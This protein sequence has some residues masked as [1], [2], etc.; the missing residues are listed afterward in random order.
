MKFLGGSKEKIPRLVYVDAVKGEKKGEI[1]FHKDVQIRQISFSRF[2]IIDPLLGR[3]GRWVKKN[4]QRVSKVQ[5]GVYIGYNYSKLQYFTR[6]YTLSEEICETVLVLQ[7][8]EKIS[9]PTSSK[10]SSTSTS[11]F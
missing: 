7:S 1:R 8:L 2:Y 5:E 3:D 9:Q 10:M 6:F 4:K 11:D